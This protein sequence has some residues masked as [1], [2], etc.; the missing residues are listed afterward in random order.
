MAITTYT[1]ADFATIAGAAIIEKAVVA[2]FFENTPVMFSSSMFISYNVAFFES[3]NLL[4]SPGLFDITNPNASGCLVNAPLHEDTAVAP[5]ETIV[6][7]AP[8]ICRSAA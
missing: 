1:I 8:I 7:F 2:A 6:V 3:P 4:F 5:G